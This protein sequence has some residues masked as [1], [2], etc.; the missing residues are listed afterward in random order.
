MRA[1]AAFCALFVLAA[2][3]DSPTDTASDGSIRGTVTDNTGANVA[4]AAVEL[5]GNE[6][7]ARSTNSGPNG[8][9][10]FADVAPGTYTLT[11]TPP[12]GF[13]IGA[14]STVPVT[15]AGDAEANPSAFVLA[16]VIVNG[17][18]RGTVTD[19][20]AAVGVANAA[21]ALTGNGQPARAT[22]SGADG[23]Y[24]FA[25]LPPGTYSLA[26]TAP[27]GFTVSAWGT[28]AITVPNGAQ[29][30][31]A[32]YM[33]HD[34]CL[35]ARPD[36]GGPATAEERALFA[37]DVDAPLNLQQ[38]IVSTQNG[39][40]VSNISYTSPDG[41]SVPG[42]LVEPIGRS[43]PHA[44]L[45]IMH[46][47]G[48]PSSGLAPYASMLAQRGAVVIAID[49]PY[50]RRGGTPMLWL[51]GQD[52]AEQIQ[53][54]KDLQR[55]VDV[56]LARPDVDPERIGFEGYSYGG[57]VGSLLVGVERRLKAAVLA[58]AMS[59]HV[60]GMTT[61]ANLG[62]LSAMSCAARNA[63]LNAMTPIE[64]L[65]F[66]PIASPTELLFQI[67]RF[68]TAVPFADAEALASAASEPRD[69]RIYE[70]GHSLNAQALYERQL[71]LHQ[72]LGI[73]PPPPP[74]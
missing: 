53:L 72:Q 51:T 9:Y 73:D 3:G 34:S 65:R 41:G 13:T 17:S 1:A 4:N 54:I 31:A 70:T 64:G 52:R 10:T 47:S 20:D 6:Q 12:A 29:A 25:D 58:A 40:R 38:T 62:Q 26:V 28:A 14:A 43:G 27:P 15:V 36:F 61:Q 67:G 48:F 5:S 68:D 11:I 19:L 21:V 60:T 44:G 71:W 66:I 55:A 33:T 42:I 35:V 22:S 63:W 74:Q 56:L 57:I 69:V 8:V 59:G 39:V 30:N 18:I 24:S 50:F 37:Y 49:A 23:V 32:T 45:V 16:R 2:C 46:P 7:D